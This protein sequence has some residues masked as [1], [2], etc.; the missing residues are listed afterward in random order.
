MKTPVKIIHIPHSLNLTRKQHVEETRNTFKFT[1]QDERK[2]DPPQLGDVYSEGSESMDD[3]GPLHAFMMLA[4]IAFMAA[5][6]VYY[7]TK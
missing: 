2:F 5:S 3:F 4:A 1:R 7:L 6:I